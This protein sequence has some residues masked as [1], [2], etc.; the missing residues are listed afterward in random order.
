MYWQHDKA[1]EQSMFRNK[2]LQHCY[3]LLTVLPFE[4]C[5]PKGLSL[6]SLCS[7]IATYWKSKREISKKRI[8]LFQKTF[9]NCKLVIVANLISPF[10]AVPLSKSSIKDW[11]WRIDQ[12]GSVSVDDFKDQILLSRSK[13]SRI[14][15]KWDLKLKAET[16]VTTT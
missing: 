13:A 8:L 14:R 7:T 4:D 3:S 2:P 15:S 9:K 5:P 10:L 16:F 11:A 12:L 1:T 6:F